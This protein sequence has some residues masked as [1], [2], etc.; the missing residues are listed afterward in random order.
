MAFKKSPSLTLICGLKVFS[1]SRHSPDLMPS[2][3]YPGEV[4]LGGDQSREGR[5][6]ANL[7]LVLSSVDGDGNHPHDSGLVV[8][9]DILKTQDVTS[10]LLAVP[11][12]GLG[13][14]LERENDGETGIRSGL[15]HLRNLLLELMGHE[16]HEALLVGDQTVHPHGTKFSGQC[17]ATS[18]LLSLT[19]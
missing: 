19:Y 11:N 16:V 15:L 18:M 3:L 10:A 1:C 17:V 7:L 12:Y 8:A 13:G 5:Q 2:S 9:D 4:N 14:G 6:G